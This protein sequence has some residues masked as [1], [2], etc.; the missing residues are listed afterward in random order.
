M[1][2]IVFKDYK[3]IKQAID[4]L[5][6]DENMI[7][8]SK[9]PHLPVIP[10]RFGTYNYN[11][12]DI[13]KKY[14]QKQHRDADVFVVHRIDIDT[15]GLVLLAKNE[16][17]HKTLNDLFEERKIDK[18]YLAV[19][20][21]HLPVTE[22]LI[23]KPILK[24]VRKMVVHEKGKP[25]KTEY[26][27][28][29]EFDKYSLVLLKPLTGRTHQLRVHL[30][31]IGCPLAVDPIYGKSDA[32]YLHQIKDNFHY[33]KQQIPRPLCARLTLHAYQLKFTESISKKQIDL[34]APVPKDFMAVLKSLRKYNSHNKTSNVETKIASES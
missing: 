5:Y 1:T 10:D 24:T 4:F 32:F 9:P 34:E 23:N 29:Q 11:L 27:V 31:S 3:N 21:G 7:V 20:M 15:T 26:K 17:Y 6:E 22:G 28:L 12:R 8:V 2:K 16:Q 18:Y 19:I 14:L 33:K 13:V 30:K 25:S